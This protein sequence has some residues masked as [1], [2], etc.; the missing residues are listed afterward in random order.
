MPIKVTVKLFAMLREKAGESEARLELPAGATVAAAVSEMGRR[1]PP[2]NQFMN[3][4]SFAVNREYAK[5][6]RTLADGDEL[7]LI[8]AVSGGIW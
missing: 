7:A 6:D 8:P 4:T 3:K 5:A 1:F 2:L